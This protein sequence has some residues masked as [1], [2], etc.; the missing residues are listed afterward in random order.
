MQD[1]VTQPDSSD[2][3][4]E[5][6]PTALQRYQDPDQVTGKQYGEQSIIREPKTGHFAKGSIANPRGR[7]TKAEAKARRSYLESLRQS[8]EEDPEPLAAAVRKRALRGDIRAHT[9]IRD[10][11]YG[12]PEKTVRVIDQAGPLAGLLAGIAGQIVDGEYTE[13]P[14]SE[15]AQTSS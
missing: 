4:P 5:S 2:S 6:L 10:T 14:S 13:L 11:L 8:V 12:T 9:F 1:Q 15:D 3:T 7:P